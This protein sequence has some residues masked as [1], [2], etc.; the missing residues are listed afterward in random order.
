M[1]YKRKLIARKYKFSR[2]QN[3]HRCQDM[4]LFGD[5]FNCY[6]KKL[7]K[8]QSLHEFC[9]KLKDSIFGGVANKKY[10][11]VIKEE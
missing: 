4:C 11:Y 8:Y 3:T 9:C 7:N 5:E 2:I 6:D 10:T 1:L